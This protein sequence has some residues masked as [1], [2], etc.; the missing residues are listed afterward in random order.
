MVGN[1]GN[2]LTCPIDLNQVNLVQCRQL[3]AALLI[4]LKRIIARDFS[5]LND[6]AGMHSTPVVTVDG[7]SGAGKGTLSSLLKN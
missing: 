6:G 1:A 5:N 4:S 7:P 2:R 3:E